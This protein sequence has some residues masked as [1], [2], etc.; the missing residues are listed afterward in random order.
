MFEKQKE[1]VAPK[2]KTGAQAGILAAAWL[3]IAA[4]VAVIVIKVSWIGGISLMLIVV[5]LYLNRVFTKEFVYT[6]TGDKLTVELA[7]FRQ[8]K[9]A[10]GS[11]VFLEDLEICAAV[12]DSAHNDALKATYSQ[13][14]DARRSPKSKT[15]FFAAF[16]REGKRTLVYFEPVDMLLDEMRKY[17]SDKIFG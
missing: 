13:T 1:F 8:N 3:I 2:D 10:V 14:I 7:D 4:I 12:N 17:A 5:P 15:A 16:E 9:T 6:L 11:P